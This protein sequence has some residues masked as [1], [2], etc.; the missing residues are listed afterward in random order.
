MQYFF[1][2]NEIKK[3]FSYF[4]II[5][6]LEFFEIFN[7]FRI[8]VYSSFS[9]IQEKFSKSLKLSQFL[10]CLTKHEIISKKNIVNG[11]LQFCIKLKSVTFVVY[12]LDI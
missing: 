2:L 12:D 4:P 6:P 11:S 3:N 1:Q 8:R 7:I 5:L 9:N 10:N